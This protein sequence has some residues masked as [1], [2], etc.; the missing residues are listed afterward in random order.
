MATSI[1][2]GRGKVA[3]SR[4]QRWTASRR[5]GCGAAARAA[6]RPGAQRRL[7]GVEP[8]AR[9]GRPLLRGLRVAAAVVEDEP[10]AEL[11]A[12]AAAEHGQSGRLGEAMAGHYGLIRLHLKAWGC[13]PHP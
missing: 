2:T 1:R 10:R 7:P 11:G 9:A 4:P 12:A 5:E 6:A 3:A 13:P 8:A